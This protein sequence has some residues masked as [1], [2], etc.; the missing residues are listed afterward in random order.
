MVERSIA[1]HS[2]WGIRIVAFL[3]DGG[4]PPAKSLAGYEGRKVIEIRVAVGDHVTVGQTLILLEAM[5]M[6]HPMRAATDGTV[7]EI[8]VEAGEQV[9]SERLLLVIE[10]DPTEE[11]E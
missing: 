6:E 8:L 1:N 3:D 9:E 11:T 2:E 5:K 10:P 7:A 4:A